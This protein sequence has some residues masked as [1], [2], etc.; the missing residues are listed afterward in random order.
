MRVSLS[1]FLALCVLLLA[2]SAFAGITATQ[3]SVKGAGNTREAAGTYFD[4]FIAVHD[5]LILPLV[6]D[7]SWKQAVHCSNCDFFAGHPAAKKL[8]G[9][10]SDV[11]ATSDEFESGGMTL[12]AEGGIPSKGTMFLQAAGAP[13]AAIFV[14]SDQMGYGNCKVPEPASLLMV[15]TGLVAMA[16]V[17]RR[18]L[19]A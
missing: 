4:Q 11:D 3:P 6:N 8:R 15:G 9:L 2:V 5:Q 16:G 18:K 7:Q 13:A 17:L 12:L 1:L 14:S 10:S 19:L